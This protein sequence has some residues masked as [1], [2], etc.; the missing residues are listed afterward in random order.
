MH[1]LLDPERLALALEAEADVE[2]ERLGRGGGLLVVLAVGVE[3]R[4][5]G[6]LHPAAGVF[7][8]LGCDAFAHEAFVE[9]LGEVEFAREVHHGA[10][11]AL[12]V[13]HEERRDACG[14][15]HAGVVCTERRGD[16][17][18]ARTV[19]CGH[20]VARDHAE[21]LLRG[22]VP[23]AGV[24][25]LHGFH[26][27]QQLL[28]AD[29]HVGQF[30]A[31]PCEPRRFV[32]G[33]FLAAEVGVH[34]V[35]GQDDVLRLLRIGVEAL[36]LHV[37]DGRTYGQRR[38]RGQRPRGCGPC[39]EEGVGRI[40]CGQRVA[41]GGA[42]GEEGFAPGV[43][44]DAELRRA[45][46]VLHVAVASGLVQLVG[47]E[48]RSRG[49]RVGLD[50]VALVEEPLVVELAQQPPEGFDVLVV[51]GDVRI[52]H[53]HPVAHAAR[54]VL[55]Y[56]RELHD[57][58]AARAVVLLDGDRAADVL[59][60]DA[61]L[62]LHAQLHGQAVRVPSR[63]AVHEEAA[64]RAVAADHVLD[65]AGHDVVDARQSVGRGGPFVE[66]EGGMS[67]AGGDALAERVVR[68]PLFQH[69]VGRGG[70]V[71]PFV[72]LE[73]HGRMSVIFCFL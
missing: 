26:P 36:E 2:V 6:V 4:I 21:R 72:L 63:L 19:L 69:F 71:E 64:L 41:L 55:P 53:V 15:G 3:L 40:G 61:E 28:V 10:R 12:A 38:V 70:Q 18:D 9:L 37:T 24:V 1:V 49:G 39:Q 35:F 32:G 5:V 68:V 50:G 56:A 57:G 52:L 7:G 13:D 54:E 11:L 60:G 66:H 51:V 8:I 44:H 17:H 62:L 42:R 45:G 25:A 47:R 73:F 27:R 14:A 43:A 29:A 48:A 46:G 20:V 59:L 16:V 67:L 33:V 22:V 58:F 23:A 65:R 34:E 30:A 31:R